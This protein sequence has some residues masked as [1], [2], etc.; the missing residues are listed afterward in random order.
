M[1]TPR[2]RLPNA[3]CSLE[4]AQ[5]CLSEGDVTKARKLLVKARKD[6][7]NLDADIF[8]AHYFASDTAEEL[9]ILLAAE[10]RGGSVRNAR[11]D[12]SVDCSYRLSA[13]QRFVR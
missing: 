10:K 7:R 6:P 9:T 3:P 12:V 11:W 5:D 13:T 1:G 4:D 2:I 8:F